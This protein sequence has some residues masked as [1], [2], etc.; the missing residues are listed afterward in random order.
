MVKTLDFY[1]GERNKLDF[2]FI[3]MDIYILFN[4][5]LFG[6]ETAKVVYAI[7]YFQGMAFNW[8]KTY[9]NDFMAY[10]TSEGRVIIIVRT[11]IQ[12]IFTN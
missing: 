8:I 12:E 10:K 9:I 1:Y 2:F 11:T 4:T 3:L 5:Y 6:I 7:N